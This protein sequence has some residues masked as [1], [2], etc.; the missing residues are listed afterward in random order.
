MAKGLYVAH[1]PH[2]DGGPGFLTGARRQRLKEELVDRLYTFDL[3]NRGHV[4]FLRLRT[5]AG[6]PLSIGAGLGVWFC[7]CTGI[8]APRARKILKAI[9][10]AATQSGTLA[11]L[12][13]DSRPAAVTVKASPD[14]RRVTAR[15]PDGVPTAW[16]TY[17]THTIFGFDHG[18]EANRTTAKE[19]ADAVAEPLEAPVR[20]G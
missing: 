18:D 10:N 9:K 1:T 14:L 3:A 11:Q 4:H 17:L 6:A 20:L 12:I 15:D 13:A 19:I 2:A 8:R 7:C 5:P 16:D